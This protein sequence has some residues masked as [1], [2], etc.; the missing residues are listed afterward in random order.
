MP[1]DTPTAEDV[2]F[3]V[4]WS[5]EQN[6]TVFVQNIGQG[7][8]VL[9][10]VPRWLKIQGDT[11]LDSNDAAWSALASALTPIRRSLEP[12]IREEMRSEI[13][14]LTAEVERLRSLV[15]FGFDVQRVQNWRMDH[16]RKPANTAF[17]S[18]PE[19]QAAYLI[20][21]AERAVSAWRPISEAPKDGT[22]VLVRYKYETSEDL[23]CHFI[24]EAWFDQYS[25]AAAEWKT[26]YG[27][28]VIPGD[29]VGW[30]P[31]P[32]DAIADRDREGTV[33]R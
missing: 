4:R 8:C 33:G 10:Q 7:V 24:T 29:V 30:I 14:R 25:C 32:P 20:E 2:A 13:D 3:A 28:H 26:A 15:R 18:G 22:H 5:N 17:T 23:R 21:D 6:P 11:Y 27:C 31:K 1:T 9:R 19:R 16:D 12:V